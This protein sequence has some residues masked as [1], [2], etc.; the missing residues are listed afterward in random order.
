MGEKWDK[1]ECRIRYVQGDRIGLEA[2]ANLSG[3]PFGT[4]KRWSS[5]KPNTWLQQRRAFE[6]KTIRLAERKS[7]DRVSDAIAT[8]NEAIITQHLGVAKNLRE[9]SMMFFDAVLT[10]LKAVETETPQS[11]ENE[12]ILAFLGRI[13]GRCPLAVYSDVG[14]LAVQLERQ[15][16]YLD[17]VDPSILEKAANRQRLSLVNLDVVE[18]PEN[19]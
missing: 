1:D 8:N 13:A 18:N 7:M 6:E 10:K 17:F 5:Q 3:L 12:Q 4:L 16:L 19:A 15:A 14:R 11:E 2:L 9:L